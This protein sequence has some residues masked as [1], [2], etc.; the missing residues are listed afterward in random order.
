MQFKSL[1]CD[2]M[3]NFLNIGNNSVIVV[4]KNLKNI[5]GKLKVGVKIIDLDFDSV[6]KMYGAAHC[7]SQV[8]KSHYNY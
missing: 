7:C 4:N 8:A 5:L 3:I 2:Y 6:I 1:K